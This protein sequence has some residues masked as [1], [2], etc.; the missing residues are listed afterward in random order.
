MKLQIFTV[1]V[2]LTSLTSITACNKAESK[3]VVAGEGQ[4]MKTQAEDIVKKYKEEEMA[5]RNKGGVR[6]NLKFY[7]TESSPSKGLTEVSLTPEEKIYVQR[8]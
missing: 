1:L 5:S 4:D 2:L 6:E 3:K 7:L 8:E